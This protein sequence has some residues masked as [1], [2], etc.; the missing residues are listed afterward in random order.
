MIKTYFIEEYK[1]KIHS[2]FDKYKVAFPDKVVEKFVKEYS[3]KGD[4]VFDPF[5]H[6][7]DMHSRNH[8]AWNVNSETFIDDVSEYIW[9]KYKQN[10]MNCINCHKKYFSK[11]SINN[12][13]LKYRDE[14]TLFFANKIRKLAETNKIYRDYIDEAKEQMYV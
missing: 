1:T 14:V 10:S 9:C 3:K 7:D 8:V 2:K 5:V 12:H 6:K 11:I 13:V 4:V